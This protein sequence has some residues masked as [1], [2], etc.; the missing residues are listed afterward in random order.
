MPAAVRTAD[1]HITGHLCHTVDFLDMPLGNPPYVGVYAN[2]ILMCR[3]LDKDIG[4]TLPCPC[5]PSMCCCP[6]VMPLVD[7]FLTVQVQKKAQSTIGSG[8]DAGA[9]VTGSPDVFVC[10]V[11]AADAKPPAGASGFGAGVMKNGAGETIFDGA[12]FVEP[13]DFGG[14]TP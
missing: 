3:I 5:P 7:G 11:P 10:G 12:G 9:M 1:K 14:I 6:H 13:A 8:I 4:H 2:H